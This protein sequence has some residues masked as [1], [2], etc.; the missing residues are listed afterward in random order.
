MDGLRKCFAKEFS[1]IYVFNLRGNARTQGE[2]RQREKGNVFG[3]GSRAPI[4]ITILVKAPHDGDAKI[5]YRDIGDY[6]TRE[7]KLDIINN[8]RNVLDESFAP[9]KPNDRGDWINQRGEDFDKFIALAPDKKFDGASES[10]FVTY[11]NGLKSQRDAWCYNFSRPALESNMQTTIDYYNTH[12]ATDF[13]ATKI[14]WTRATVQ[15]KNCGREYIF[16]AAQIVESV[17]RPF[18]KENL[19]YDLRLNEM[20]Y[21]M[22]RLF[23]NGDEENFLIGVI[24]G[25]K[26]FSVLMTDKITDVQFQFNG[27]CFPLYWYERDAQGSLFGE[28]LQRRDGVSDFIWVRAKLLYGASVTREDIFYYVYGFLHLPGYR[29]KFSAELKKS[30]P[31]IFLTDAEKFWQ[32]SK[33]GRELAEIHLNYETQP[34]ADVKVI[35]AEKNNFAVKKMR[36]AKDDRTTLIYNEHIKIKNIPPRSF[37]YVVNGRSPLE[38]IIDR[39]Q[40]KTDKASGIV[41]DP[42]AWGIEHDNPRY[43]LDL[44]LSA[45]T[46]SLKTLDIV[47]NLPAV[48]FDA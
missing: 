10:F 30:L 47:E 23:P 3:S 7:R 1:E 36:F 45:I 35:G 11:S 42:N 6:L 40:I 20:T 44:I 22:P 43:I 26:N 9:L 25:E 16:N 29:E 41:N 32:L 17:Y 5:F 24:F 13:D 38:W 34:P 14:T 28:N 21:Q 4:A 2:L 31:R 15:N 19:Y 18:C 8:T 12:N 27:Q 33:A 46:V 39:Y 48:E 37:D